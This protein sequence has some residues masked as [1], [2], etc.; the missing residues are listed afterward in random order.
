MDKQE[1][2]RKYLDEELTPTEEREA[3]HIIADDEELRDTL[4]FDF[5]LRQSFAGQEF[6]KE[7]FEVPDKFTDSVM[8]QIEKQET[9]KEFEAITSRVTDKIKVWVE[10]LFT[11]RSYQLKPAYALL[12]FIIVILSPAV[13]F[14]LSQ[15]G[16]N[17]IV[18][19][20]ENIQ[21][22]MVAE[23][24]ELVWVRFIYV[25]DNAD[26]IAIAGDFNSWDPKSLSKQQV[27]GQNVWTG[28]FSMPPGEHKYMFVVNG[29]KWVTDPLANMYQDDGFGNKNAILYL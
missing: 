11:P 3:L 26:S 18:Q 20:E 15:T 17:E 28:F 12:L 24:E 25:D 9:Q 13:P 1:L 8:M 2:L 23:T 5:F 10:A 6:S 16:D 22:Q 29:E 7:T 27:N 14:Y 4:R 21:T 19:N